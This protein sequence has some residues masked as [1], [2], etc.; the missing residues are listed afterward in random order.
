MRQ[1]IDISLSETTITML[2]QLVERRQ[3]SRFIE[4]AL[5]HYINFLR[6]KGLR[7]RLKEGALARA[8]RDLEMADEWFPLEQEIWDRAK[9][10]KMS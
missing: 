6:R 1:R 8:E 3:R 5:T 2:N 10:E 4:E 9:E 7:E